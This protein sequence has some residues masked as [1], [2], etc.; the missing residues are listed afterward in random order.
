MRTLVL[1]I[2]VVSVL[3]FCIC[4]IFFMANYPQVFSCRE[5]MW[6]PLAVLMLLMVWRLGKGIS[7]WGLN[8]SPMIIGFIVSNICYLVVLL[9]YDTYPVSDWACVWQAAN[10]MANDTFTGGLEKGHYMHEIPYQLGLAFVESLFIRAFGNC[11]GVLQGVNV[12]FLNLAT[13]LVYHFTK[14]KV[15][16][17]AANYAFMAACLFLCFTM[18]VSQFTNHQVSFV[19]LYFALF[20]IEKDLAKAS[21]LSGVVVALLNFVRPMG[22]LIIASVCCFYLY[23]MLKEKMYLRLASHLGLFLIGFFVVAFLL[24]TML[25]N[26]NYTDE[27]VSMSSR[28]KYHKIS[29]TL[30]DSKVDG[31]IADYQ[32]DY[33]RYNED[34][35]EELI[36]QVMNH[37]AQITMSVA[38]KMVRYLG[39]F[40]YLFEMTYNH[41]E[42]VWMRY[43]VK[44]IYST[45]WFQ[46]L[47]YL[48]LA[49]YG[50]IK[51]SKRNK[52]DVY[53]I[54]F[55][56]NTLV[57]VFIEAFTSYRFINYFYLLFLVGIAFSAYSPNSE[58]INIGKYSHRQVKGVCCE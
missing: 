42:K 33:E 31:H 40:D 13:F 1:S 8:I 57:Y 46:Y 37:P 45:Q 41:D 27:R 51:Y 36:S 16:I 52:M 54:F 19:L 25:L 9:T 50:Y 2:L 14:R 6:F 23:K 17:Q 49:I 44:A 28:N 20:L 43:P 24:D 26:L 3:S 21:L 4:N 39:L 38:N 47:L 30:Y 34:Y 29:Y 10:E 56:A 12:I 53:Q 15:S 58:T 32:F 35:R 55:V 48:L 18:T 7:L 22:I 5:W 11:Y